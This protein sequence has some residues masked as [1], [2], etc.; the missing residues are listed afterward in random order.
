MKYKMGK[1]LT[2]SSD[3]ESGTTS[4]EVDQSID[5]FSKSCKSNLS[6]KNNIKYIEAM[7]MHK[8]ELLGN[9]QIFQLFQ[10]GYRKWYVSKYLIEGQVTKNTINETF[11]QLGIKNDE[12]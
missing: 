10:L 1:A 12:C 2:K 3:S 6:S 9:L 8:S 11:N 4:K 5:Y 7:F